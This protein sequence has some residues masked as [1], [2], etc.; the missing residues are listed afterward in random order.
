MTNL[1]VANWL[2]YLEG[3]LKSKLTLILRDIL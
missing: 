3:N 1:N 2:K